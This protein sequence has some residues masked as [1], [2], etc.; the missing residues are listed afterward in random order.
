VTSGAIVATAR[1]IAAG[2]VTA[3]AAVR[4]CL[5]RIDER[6]G[7]LHS[8]VALR[9]EE[10]LHEARELDVALD[11]D[12]VV[13]GPLHGVPVLVKDLEDVEGMP[14]RKG[15]RLFADAPPATEDETI[16]ARLR[17]AGAVIVGKTNL[18]EFATEGFSD[19]LLD[20]PTHNP[21]DLRMSPGGSS[22]GA[23]A[24]LA[25]GIVPIATAT[26]GGGSVRI[27][28]GLCGLLGLKPTFGAVGR[29]PAAD[30]LDLTTYGPLATT[31]E[32]L[33]LL[34]SLMTGRVDGDP[35]STPALQF[36]TDQRCTRVIVAERTSPWGPLPDPV[37]PAF[38]DAAQRFAAMLDL[39]AEV[40]D[41]GQLFVDI[42]DPDVDWFTLATAEHAAAIGRD[43]V[44][45]RLSE[46]H[47]AAAGFM[48][49]GLSVTIDDYLASRRRRPAYTRIM[50]RLL[51]SD[52]V[53]LT[54]ILGVEGLLAD[55]RLL[56]TEEVEMLA[57]DVYSTP[58]QNI[59][60]HPAMSLPAGCYP[61]GF[62]FGLQVTA[63]RW[64]DDLLFD[65][66]AKWEVAYPW[67]RTAP[68][69][70]EFSVPRA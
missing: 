60:G 63:P 19:N 34:F 20:G 45:A 31:T 25:A 56:G 33:A 27:P 11:R 10:A 36:G 30:W 32:D 24:A 9:A 26:D 5:R 14:T 6:D 70:D 57:P 64:R 47:P 8:V 15:S 38:L 22:G 49:Q 69:Y 29:W 40:I 66:A 53:L 4:E 52:T 67:P 7:A 43:V 2:E 51:G 62:P 54:P 50:D 17:A 58:M 28:A 61:S 1:S 48:E 16:P 65:L 37:G 21:W 3:E 12:G 44:Q 41:G 42:G 23:G 68:G 18:P 39:E 13:R 59:T 55:G 46:M 35:S